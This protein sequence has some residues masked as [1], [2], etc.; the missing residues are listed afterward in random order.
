MK[1]YNPLPGNHPRIRIRRLGTVTGTVLEMLS[2][3]MAEITEPKIA[4][5]G[6]EVVSVVVG[7]AGLVVVLPSVVT[8]LGVVV[9][10]TVVVAVV[11]VDGEVEAT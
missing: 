7:G 5:A 2:V 9:G 11:V 10:L 8:G 1:Q 3:F 4:V 6:T